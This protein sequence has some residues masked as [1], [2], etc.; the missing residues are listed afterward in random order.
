LHGIA[1][2]YIKKNPRTDWFRE[3]YNYMTRNENFTKCPENNK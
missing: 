3:N 2:N 1:L